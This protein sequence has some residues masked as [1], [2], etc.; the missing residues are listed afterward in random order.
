MADGDLEALLDQLIRRWSGWETSRSRS[1]TFYLETLAPAIVRGDANLAAD[2][3]EIVDGIRSLLDD[4]EWQDFPRLLGDR[5]L[6]LVD[7]KHRQEEQ[8]RRRAEREE[9][10]RARQEQQRQQQEMERQRLEEQRRRDEERRQQRAQAILQ[11]ISLAFEHDFLTADTVYKR[12]PD[13]EVLTPDEYLAAKVQFVQRWA[14]KALSQNLDDEQAAAVATLGSDVLV[15]ARAGSGKTRTLATRAIF[16]ISHCRVSPRS[17]LLLAFNRRAANEMRERLEDSLNGDLPHVMTFHALAYALVHPNEELVYDEPGSD[18]LAL[19][20]VI[21]DVIDE[22]LTD[23]QHANSIRR[24]MLE[25]FRDDWEAI[26]SGGFHLEMEEFLSRRRALARET[27]R[28]DFVKSHGEKVIA[29]ALFEHGLDYAYERNRRWNGINYRPDFTLSLPGGVGVVIEYF[30]MIGDPDYDEQA[31]AKREYWATQAGWHLLEYYPQDLAESADLFVHRLV[32]DLR[33]V[34]VTAERIPEEEVWQLIRVR[35]VDRFTGAVRTFV[36]RCRKRGLSAEDLANLVEAH[37]VASPA[38]STFLE[39]AQSIHRGY[40]DRM[41]ATEQEDFDGLMWRAVEMLSNGSTRFVRDKGRERGDLAQMHHV[42]IDEFQD[43]SQMFFEITSKIRHAAPEVQFFCVGDDWQAINS[44]AGSD[45]RFFRQFD[46][47]FA[48][49]QTVQ[50]RTNYRSPTVVVAAGNAVMEGRGPAAR[51]HRHDPGVVWHCDL[52]RFQPTA[53]EQDRHGGDEITP[54]VLRLV[55]HFLSLDQDVV[56]LSRRNGVSWYVN[57][58]DREDRTPDPLERFLA[59]IRSFLPTEDRR[60]VTISTAHK[61]KG[62][63]RSAVVVL[64][65]LEGSYPLVHPSWIFLRVFGD[66][67]QKLEEEER[68]LFY[69][70]VTRSTTSLSLV[71]EQL[72]ASPYLAGIGEAV[73]LPEAPWQRLPPA[74]S[75]DDPRVEICVSH[76]FEVKDELRRTGFKWNPQQRYW[77]RSYPA[78]SYSEEKLIAKPWYRDKVQ[79]EVRSDTGEI[80]RPLQPNTG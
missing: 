78:D 54:A 42:L 28:G 64:D 55:Q 44:F 62:L 66:T 14:S 48:D 77:S 17:M 65:A 11:R 38:E 20:R 15:T 47:Y 49:N 5:Q 19:S 72:R 21:Q 60:R 25:H 71:T 41:A 46:D 32:D 45:L 61:Y 58:L 40:I 50:I 26:V 68:R 57:Y 43:F 7:E 79:V 37:A 12:D 9:Q 10:D 73:S 52:E 24:V 39:L 80:V 29:N 70:A 76:A 27:L 6:W 2:E 13:R 4:E 33:S 51:P 35:A 69:V 22:H 1:R 56:L 67:L 53:V 30:G 23:P 75:L 59:Q 18:S 31:T 8:A 3:Q 34:G 36:A 74:P 16:L 63:E